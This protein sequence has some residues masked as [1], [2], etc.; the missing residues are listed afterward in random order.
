M[1]SQSSKFTQQGLD[2]KHGRSV[3]TKNEPENSFSKYEFEYL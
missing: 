2:L 3:R 1:D